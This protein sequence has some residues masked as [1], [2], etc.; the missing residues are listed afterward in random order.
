MPER[1]KNLTQHP[2]NLKQIHYCEQS[3]SGDQIEKIKMVRHVAR[4]GEWSG[5]YRDLVAKH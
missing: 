2:T 3:C 5:V 4:M 1:H